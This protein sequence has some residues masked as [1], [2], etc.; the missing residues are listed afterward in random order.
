V[1][2]RIVVNLKGRH[3]R[4]TLEGR[5]HLVVP[6]VI[7]TEGV[8]PGSAGPLFYPAEE[9]G[10]D[11]KAWDH[12]PLVAD[13]PQEGDTFVSART[14]EWINA[15][16]MGVLLNTKHKDKLATECWFDEER[17]KEIDK[18]VYDA[19]KA[20]KGMEVSTGLDLDV[21]ETP[22]EYKGAKY[23]GIAR[24]HRPDHLAIL[25]DKLG[26][27]K[28]AGL[29]VN[30]ERE[31]ESTQQAL[32]RTVTNL[33]RS[34]GVGLV[35]NELSFSGI[36]RMLSDLLA[37]TYG[38]K[39]RY[40]DGY[41]CEVYDS[42]VI[43]SNGKGQLYS[44]GYTRSDAGV[45]LTGDAVPVVRV[46]EYQTADGADGY[47]ANTAEFWAGREPGEALETFPPLTPRKKETAMADKTALVTALIGNGYEETDRAWLTA[48]PVDA[49]EKIKPVP[50]AVTANVSPPPPPPA[51]P[52]VSPPA[53][54]QHQTLKQI[55]ANSGD[56]VAAQ[57]YADMET[58]YT[59]E[60]GRLIEKISKAPG[61]TFTEAILKGLPV[62][63]LRMIAALIPDEA[64]GGMVD[65]TRPFPGAPGP[66][67]GAAGG[68]VGNAETFPAPPMPAD[69]DRYGEI[70]DEAA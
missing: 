52:P 36:T 9:N 40:W 23:Y 49:L 3:R 24:N 17:T 50:K 8:V 2:E 33:L 20:N 41:I 14:P 37:S 28:G 31:P 62:A 6:A 43:F 29:F 55:I 30:A 48:L 61:N 16:K 5:P 34:V 35:G 15:R 65:W 69:I 4:D 51:V 46:V 26:A 67:A 64:G 21:E 58:T 22:G 18:R 13:H 10:R 39:G 7:L 42:Y 1:F 54:P 19:I 68:P 57:M 44:V 63:N 11:P 27:C 32:S 12:M 45:A 66:F 38:E 25:P 59:S 53:P 70:E 47:T 56:P 60:Q